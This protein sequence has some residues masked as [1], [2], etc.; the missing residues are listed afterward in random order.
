ML[1]RKPVFPRI[2]FQLFLYFFVLIVIAVL[3]FSGTSEG[4]G[5]FRERRRAFNPLDFVIPEAADIYE[6]NT[7]ISNWH[8]ENH[9]IWSQQ[10]TQ[11]INEDLVISYLAEAIMRG[12]YRPA[13][14]AIPAAFLNSNQRTYNSMV[15]LGQ[16][17]Q[18][19]R[20]LAASDQD[21]LNRISGL[22]SEENY[23]ELLSEKDLLSFLYIRGHFD[24]LERVIEQIN[25]IEPNA[26][27]IS[28]LPGIFETYINLHSQNPA[29]DANSAE[30]PFERLIERALELISVSLR[31]NSDRNRV[32]IITDDNSI[33]TEFNLRL[34]KA[35]LEW[36]EYENNEG[37]AN[38]ARSIILSVLW[39]ENGTED[40]IIDPLTRLD[41]AGINRVLGLDQYRPQ[42]IGLGNFNNSWVWAFTLDN[43][44]N[45]AMQNNALTIRVNFPVGESH[46]MIIRGIRP[47]SIIQ[48]YGMNYPSD[49][50]FERYDS[51]GWRY[52][53]ADQ[54]LLIKV[55]H[56]SETENIVIL[57][58]V[59]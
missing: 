44:I 2:M 48:I 56:R 19:A 8:R 6:F 27:T 57:F 13:I 20:I 46:Y 26:I 41:S 58:P 54:T 25:V 29:F 24:L 18:A 42:A 36:A 32:L 30:N 11:Q 53:A 39:M 7:A 47:F 49:P 21:S 34:A 50:Q 43:T 12:N 35:L 22:L 15:F 51:S 55:R 28:Q 16:T 59:S 17:E 45:T 14:S 1:G 23:S 33:N 5:F 10:I 38:L 3:Q 40:F 52:F 4:P 31:M 9:N 37:W